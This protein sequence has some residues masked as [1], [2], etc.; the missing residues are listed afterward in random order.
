M[1]A[2]ASLP[3]PHLVFSHANGFP[4]GTYRV[5]FERWRAAGLQVHALERFGHDPRYPVASNWRALRDQ[6]IDFIDAEVGGPAIL[7][8]HSLGG[9]V[10]LLAA[11]CATVW[12]IARGSRP[13]RSLWRLIRRLAG[14]SACSRATRATR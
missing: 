9:L 2:P 12:E 13:R 4:A 3:C 1:T 5:L 11:L 8:G 7:V 6:L 10:S 14:L